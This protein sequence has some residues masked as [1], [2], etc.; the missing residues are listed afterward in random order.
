MAFGEQGIVVTVVFFLVLVLQSF[1]VLLIQFFKSLGCY[2]PE[3]SS[4]LINGVLPVVALYIFHD[5]VSL[6]ELGL[7]I[8]AVRLILILYQLWVF[9][10]LTVGQGW[11]VP[12]GL[13]C[14]LLSDVFYAIQ[15]NFKYAIYSVLG[16]VFLSVD[17]VLMRFF[18]GPEDT[19]IY[20][21]AMRVIVAA[22]LLFEVLI[23]VFIPRLA[24]SSELSPIQFRFDVRKFATIMM[25]GAGVMSLILLSL[26]PMAINFAFGTEFA[27]AGQV[28]R[29]LTIVLVLRVATEVV[30]S[31]LTVSGLQA[32]RAKTIVIV[33][34]IHISLNV[35][36]Q[37]E[38]GIW[39]AVI[40][41]CFSFL[42]WLIFNTYFLF[43]NM[44]VVPV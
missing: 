9:L 27:D 42:F 7:L 29:F 33:L 5:D 14:Q 6:V 35:F 20:G 25:A 30:G 2:E 10:R 38:F 37:P 22:I 15:G 12:G 11:N 16:A 17:I 36:L 13:V 44:P 39:G 34:P 19:A 8:L 4:A 3:L 28:V 43:K 1:S 21:T 23:G 24:R 31:I 26:G 32:F 41:L 40:S 18:L